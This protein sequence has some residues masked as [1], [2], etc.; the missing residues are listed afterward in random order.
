MAKSFPGLVWCIHLPCN[1]LFLKCC[2]ILTNSLIHIAEFTSH[3]YIEDGENYAQ[4]DDNENGTATV[5][6]PTIA[7]YENPQYFEA[8]R[9]PSVSMWIYLDLFSL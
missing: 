6:V 7:V 9:K 1:Q 3:D 8:Q 4:I 5:G 2:S